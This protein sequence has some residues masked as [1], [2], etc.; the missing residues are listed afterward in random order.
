MPILNIEGHKVKVDDSFL[1]LSPEEQNA[2]VDEIAQ[3][4]EIQ[5]LPQ[6]GQNQQSMALRAGDFLKH[7]A[8]NALDTLSLGWNDEAAA[9]LAALP[10]LMPGGESY[11]EAYDRLHKG[12]QKLVDEADQDT[13]AKVA[14]QTIGL[15]PAMV[16]TGGGNVLGNAV[17]RATPQMNIAQKAARGTLE[18]IGPAATTGGRV[19]QGATY[20][21]AAAGLSQGG[22]DTGDSE[23]YD[24]YLAAGTGALAGGAVAGA[25]E[26]LPAIVGGVSR[27]IKGQSPNA[28]RKQAANRIA[29]RAFKDELSPEQL[30]YAVNEAK[31]VGADEFTILDAGGGNVRG[32]ARTTA[33]T[34]GRG[35]NILRD[36]VD[37]RNANQYNRNIRAIEDHLGPI[38]DP[39]HV[40]ANLRENAKAKFEPL[41]KI[42]HEGEIVVDKELA[43]ALYNRP[44]AR[45][46]WE[47][48]EKAFLESGRKAPVIRKLNEK[49]P[50]SPRLMSIE[51][52]HYI[53]EGIDRKIAKEKAIDPMFTTSN[54]G[55]L[56]T[57]T[58][59]LIDSRLKKDPGMKFADDQFSK[60]M[61][62]AEAID[63]G[64]GYVNTR[65][66]ELDTFR[67]GASSD[68][69][70]MYREGARAR[71]ADE[72]GKIR[73]SNDISKKIMGTPNQKYALGTIAPS[74]QK[75]Q[76]MR[77]FLDAERRMEDSRYL[78][79]GNSMTSR[80]EALRAAEGQQLSE[81]AA[82]A[83]RSGLIPMVKDSIARIVEAP[84]G[85]TDAERQVIAEMLTNTSEEGLQE[86]L[87]SAMQRAIQQLARQQ[88]IGPV[89][90]L[91][92]YLIGQRTS[93]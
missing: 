44:S 84:G 46:G 72:L 48:A 13:V 82:R 58:R 8:T 15:A 50:N 17:V 11:S 51:Q 34:P 80:N 65:P 21:G 7:T 38:N 45:S 2:T 90:T 30:A 28:L 33:D 49:D 40:R 16:A 77:K 73:E 74:Q 85:I 27:M 86:F 4:L 41:Y 24:P 63:T 67:K 75:A 81:R 31:R 35:G 43:D 39:K 76:D 42:A 70:D 89:S 36:F 88:T 53:R 37:S 5:P 91:G 93:E 47:N 25:S 32:L 19:V 61:R 23:W 29:D 57:E 1:S 12:Q 26:A 60:M 10:A 71:A 78:T 69:L 3:S 22:H 20:G 54:M 14:G 62:N 64:Y 66:K 92:G 6:S 9:G 18:A 87:D 52:L 55:R 83:I 59:N 68:E 79:K 56:M